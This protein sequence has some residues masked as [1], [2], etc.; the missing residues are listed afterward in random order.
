MSVSKKQR[1]KQCQYQCKTNKHHQC[2][3]KTNKQC[4]L[5][6]P[7]LSHSLIPHSLVLS[8]A[9]FPLIVISFSSFFSVSLIISFISVSSLAFTFIHFH[10]LILYLSFLRWYFCSLWV[11]QGLPSPFVPAVF[12]FSDTL[13]FSIF[14]LRFLL[15][16]IL[17]SLHLYPLI[18]FPFVISSHSP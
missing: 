18:T 14:F 3:Y 17:L 1:Y 9:F 4:Q 10:F 7:P 11:W 2:Q 15:F 16:F 13:Y 12:F 6:L 5:P 8:L